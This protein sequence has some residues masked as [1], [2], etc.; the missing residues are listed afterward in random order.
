MN[1]V[2]LLLMF[3]LVMGAGY[4]AT[5][6]VTRQLTGLISIWL[7]LIISLW[8]YKP[9]SVKILG[10]VFT[11]ASPL[12]LDSFSF[13]ML[14][15]LFTVIVQGLFIFTTKSPEEKRKK[16][17]KD[18]NEMLD[19]VDRG[20]SFGIINALGGLVVGAAVTA[21]WISIFL[22]ITQYLLNAGVGGPSLR[23]SSF[24]ITFFRVR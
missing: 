14:L 24:S 8:L 11:S 18:L 4:G 22:A 3:I 12:I 2:D 21:V 19:K 9:F 17:A 5:R 10:G 6:G 15:I 13:I 23:M 7:G 16:G 20:P 1:Y